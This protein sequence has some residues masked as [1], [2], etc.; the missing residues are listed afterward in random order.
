MASKEAANQRR[1]R[2]QPLVRFN[3]RMSYCVNQDACGVPC[4]PYNPVDF[5]HPDMEQTWSSHNI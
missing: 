1:V 4:T 5:N 3:F 2:V